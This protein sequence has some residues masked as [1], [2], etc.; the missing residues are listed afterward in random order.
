MDAET[1]TRFAPLVH[2]V[3][4][5]AVWGLLFS[6]AMWLWNRVLQMIDGDEDQGGDNDEG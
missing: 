5:F 4:V 2:T 6:G 1:W 3:V